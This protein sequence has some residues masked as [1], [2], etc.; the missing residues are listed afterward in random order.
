MHGGYER[1][2][3]WTMARPRL[4]MASFAV[5]LVATVALYMTI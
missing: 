1:S 3:T 2:L 4:V 5:T